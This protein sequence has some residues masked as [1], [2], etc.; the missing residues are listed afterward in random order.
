V[1]VEAPALDLSFM[2]PG[3]LDARITVTRASVGTYIDATGIQQTAGN[4][5]PRWEYDPVTHV[6]RGL[7]IE[8]GRTNYLLNS[9]APVSQTTVGLPVNTYMFWMVGSGSATIAAGTAV[10]TGFGSA[11][12]ASPLVFTTTGVGTVIVTLTGSVTQFQLEGT[13][14]NVFPTSFIPTAGAAV[15]RQADVVSLPVT[16]WLGPDPHTGTLF[17]EAMRLVAQGTGAGPFILNLVNSAAAG[18][19]VGLGF[20]ATNFISMRN[21]SIGDPPSSYT[22]SVAPNPAPLPFKAAHSFTPGTQLCSVGGASPVGLNRATVAGS[23]PDVLVLGGQLSTTAGGRMNGYLRRVRY[24]PRALS[25]AEL[26][27]VTT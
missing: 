23:T 19:S 14:T 3:S 12:A 25:S 1:S 24:W 4:N 17:M 27:S 7:L 6:L 18:D 2:T 22:Q 21:A 11:S 5:V 16:G 26:Q 9:A 20:L 15:I 8:D 10:G 13:G